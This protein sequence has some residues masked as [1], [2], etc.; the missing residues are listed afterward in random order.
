[1]VLDNHGG[2]GHPGRRIV[3]HPDGTFEQTLYTDI[4]G[5]EHDRAL[6]GSYRF[7]EDRKQL[8]LASPRGGAQILYREPHAGKVYWVKAGE[9]VRIHEDGEEAK[10]LRQTSLQTEKH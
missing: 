5:P 6:K 2:F 9:R 4:R 3:L 8:T 10:K 1:M 7:S